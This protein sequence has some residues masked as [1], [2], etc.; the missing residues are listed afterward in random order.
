MFK[1]SNLCFTVFCKLFKKYF[2]FIRSSVRRPNEKI[3]VK[4]NW[5]AWSPSNKDNGM[6]L[7]IFM[8]YIN[9]I[10]LF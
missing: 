2:C 9:K 4:K 10:E 3:E 8:H 1:L 7:F 5:S 6:F